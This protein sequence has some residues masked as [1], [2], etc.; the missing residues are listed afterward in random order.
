M[1]SSVISPWHKTSAE[2][3]LPDDEVVAVFL[4]DPELSSPI[5]FPY[6]Y[7]SVASAKCYCWWFNNGGKNL[8]LRSMKF[9]NY[10]ALHVE[11][12]PPMNPFWEL[13]RAE[14]LLAYYSKNKSKIL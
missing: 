1:K 11:H 8:E 3:I 6:C 9:E 5:R 13:G 4:H 2:H 12:C 14:F 7:R 10:L